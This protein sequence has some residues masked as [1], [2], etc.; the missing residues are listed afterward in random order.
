MDFTYRHGTKKDL[1][2][3]KNLAINSWKQFR[4]KLTPD[5]WQKLFD[6]LNND[7]TYTELL[8]K[9]TCFVCTTN[10][11]K[12][13]G[14]AFLVPRGNPTNTCDKEWAYIRFVTVDP[15]FGKQGIG[16]K[17]TTLCVD[18]ARNN[19]ERVIALHTSELMKTARHL[20]E[21]LGF[22]MLKEI[23]QRLGKRYWLYKLDLD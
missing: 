22:K 5:N 9:A 23:D 16:R 13:A 7:N 8:E 20:Y 12:I 4:S 18:T 17:L 14:M 15:C 2:S 11:N 1:Q 3:L 19:N 6:S 10:T 21:S